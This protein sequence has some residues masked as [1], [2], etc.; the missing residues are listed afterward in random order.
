M[1]VAALIEYVT[2][3]LPDCFYVTKKDGSLEWVDIS[4]EHSAVV[5]ERSPAGEGHK[6]VV[7]RGE[8]IEAGPHIVALDWTVAAKH[9]VALFKQA[10]KD[11]LYMV[12]YI[13]TRPTFVPHNVTYDQLVRAVPF[14]DPDKYSYHVVY[15]NDLY[16]NNG[17][18]TRGMS[19]RLGS[20]TNIKVILVECT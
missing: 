12:A 17:V 1:S 16:G 10:E 20:H 19:I 8:S 6:Y 2:Q 9:I 13:N 3:E 11:K 4:N 15:E 14:G 18:I 5:V 7:Y